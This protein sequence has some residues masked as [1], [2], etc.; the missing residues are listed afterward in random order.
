MLIFL[1]QS[2]RGEE[3]KRGREEKRGVF[4]QQTASW[5]FQKGNLYIFL[6]KHKYN[7]QNLT[8]LQ[9]NIMQTHISSFLNYFSLKLPQ[10]PTMPNVSG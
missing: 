9:A 8:D 5:A 7:H 6:S 4:E 1:Q 3:E 2:C 10:F